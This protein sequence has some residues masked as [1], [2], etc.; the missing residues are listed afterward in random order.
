MLETKFLDRARGVINPAL[1]RRKAEFEAEIDK[2][3]FDFISAG[4]RK[5]PSL[6]RMI[7]DRCRQEVGT[8]N[9]LVWEKLKE[10]HS[11]LGS[12][13]STTLADDFK[14]EVRIHRFE[15]KADLDHSIAERVENQQGLDHS[16]E[17]ADIAAE[18]ET[19]G[20]IDLYVESLDHNKAGRA[21][22]NVEPEPI[23]PI[24]FISCGQ[25]SE[26]EIALGRRLA[27]IVDTELK[28]CKGY[29]ADNQSSLEGLSKHIL[30]AL[31]RCVG[32]V[33]VMHHRGVVRTL[34]GEHIRASVWVEQEL[35]IAA[36]IQQTLARSIAVAVYFQTGIRREGIRDQ[37]ILNPTEFNHEDEVE[38]DFINRI[39]LGTFKPSVH[40]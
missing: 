25:Y 6:A 29:F 32:F 16:L 8:R 34:K 37:L 22:E 19:N 31:N 21:P 23:D 27:N 15:Q 10:V 30:G 13:R 9:L 1:S 40:T 7:V 4:I 11:L 36:F 38:K 33:A 35:A 17:R 28:P 24:V 3:T 39:R 18:Q 20:L 2:I 14:L 5:S 12:P 26:H